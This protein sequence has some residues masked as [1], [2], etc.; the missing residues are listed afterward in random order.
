MAGG[1]R[2]HDLQVRLKYAGIPARCVEGVADALSAVGDLP[3]EQPLYVLTN[4][5][6]LEPARH[7][8]ERAGEP[9]GR[10]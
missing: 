4:Y 7:E 8:L 5:S 2:A 9:H 1:L 3:V 6:A 10:K